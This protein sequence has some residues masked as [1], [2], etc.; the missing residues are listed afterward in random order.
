MKQAPVI[1][2]PFSRSIFNLDP[3]PLQKHNTGIEF[4]NVLYFIQFHN[5]TFNTHKKSIFSICHFHSVLVKK[6][7]R[8]QQIRQATDRP[9]F[10]R[11]C[12][13]SFFNSKYFNHSTIYQKKFAVK[14]SLGS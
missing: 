4:F 8:I 12:L 1:Q 13:F 5:K 10:P 2:S 3:Q 7:E 6:Y 9:V 14:Q 11:I